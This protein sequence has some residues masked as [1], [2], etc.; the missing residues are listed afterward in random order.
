M[1]DLASRLNAAL[2]GRYVIERELGE[3]GIAT[4]YL[5]ED[6]K[7]ERKVALKVLK[8]ELAAVVGAERFL[9]EIKTTA[10]LQ[11]PHILPL[12]D[13]G[14]AGS[15]LFYVMPY[16]EGESLRQKLRREH[17]LPVDDAVRLA[18]D[19]AEA[20][21]YAH[22][23]GVIHRDIK[24]G[25][26]L[27]HDGQPV[28]SDF[29]IVLALGAAG[30]NRL[31]E[32]GLS[33][34]TPHYMSPEQTTGDQT[35]GPST[36]T[37]ALGC[38]LYEM[39]IGEPPF[40]GSS[41]QV[42]LGKIIG[43]EPQS[44]TAQR[45]AVPANVDAAIANALEKLPADRFRATQDFATALA[46]PGFRHGAVAEGEAGSTVP[47]HATI[48]RTALPWGITAALAAAVVALVS[49]PPTLG[50]AVYDV[51][52]P[53]EAPMSFTGGSPDGVGWPAFSLSPQE[54]FLVYVAQ[55]PQGTELWY[56]SLVDDEA[57]PI[58]ATLGAFF[59]MV[60]PDGESVAFFS[61]FQ[62]RHVP[63]GGGEVRALLD[64]QPWSFSAHWVSMD[65]IRVHDRGG[66][67]RV[68]IVDPATTIATTQVGAG[69][70]VLP[71]ALPSE[72]V[73]CNTPSPYVAQAIHRD[74]SVARDLLQAGGSVFGSTLRFLSDGYLTFV[75][76][77]GALQIAPFDPEALEIGRPATGLQSLR[78]DGVAG[79]AQY[80]V[81]PS[82]A[83]VYA[84]G[85]NAEVG[86]MVRVSRDD[87]SEYLP[88]DPKPFITF[89][90]SPDGARLATVVV[91][92]AGLELWIYNLA[93]GRGDRW[94]SLEGLEEPR[95]SPSGEKLAV[96]AFSETHGSLVILVGDPDSGPPSDTVVSGARP[97]H[98]LSED[99][100]LARAGLAG[101]VSI[102]LSR[103][104]LEVEPFPEDLGGMTTISPDGRWAA[105]NPPRDIAA[106]RADVFL[107]RFPDGGATFPV[108]TGGGQEPVWLSNTELTYRL[109]R[110]WYTVSVSDDGPSEPRLWFTDV[111]FLDTLG[112]SHA[113]SRD[114]GVIYVQGTNPSTASFLRIRPNWAEGA[115]RA[116]DEANR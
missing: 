52:L 51:G 2:E 8:P 68:S 77:A 78:R 21:D 31:T 96:R 100:L 112:R 27:I 111:R 44:V 94:L 82:G 53:D 104:P 110:S 87:S 72:H 19:L 83:L 33:L 98:F 29:G 46:D 48:W 5:A 6:V 56:R 74:S 69:R 58:E 38:V 76:T 101:A 10:N 35:V 91:G 114:G 24:P 95:W 1:S 4:V 93:T 92:I 60:S 88:V 108:T 50:P 55:R 20:L 67:S 71:Y 9:A 81:A 103:R 3:G 105:Y 47:G 61:S 109:G 40:T 15:F 116:A 73:L 30:G 23:Q 34:G 18:T 41:P 39:L 86:R 64:V 80:A 13:S 7:H 84:P 43:G 37:Y 107:Q 54:D 97:T 113:P 75:T 115:K 26:V 16:V 12:F 85:G 59:P 65:R 70:C 22:R 32:T 89:D 11:H 66:L 99:R 102:D 62:L 25:N 79:A 90:L 63:I 49:R 45:K 36:D 17:Q 106:G 57:R 42:V 28:I 14:E